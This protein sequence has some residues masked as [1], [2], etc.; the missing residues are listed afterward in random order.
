MASNP[1]FVKDVV[2]PDRIPLTELAKEL[3]I[4]VSSLYRWILRGVRAR[5]GQRVRLTAFKLAGRTYVRREDFESYIAAINAPEGA[6]VAEQPVGKS[7]HRQLEFDLAQSELASKGVRVAPSPGT[8]ASTRQHADGPR[9][10]VSVTT[11]FVEPRFRGHPAW[12][13]GSVLQAREHAKVIRC[14]RMRYLMKTDG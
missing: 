2:T 1:G 5:N 7:R 8:V 10:F 4:H 12:D 13:S 14:M 9:P 3:G 11:R 6:S